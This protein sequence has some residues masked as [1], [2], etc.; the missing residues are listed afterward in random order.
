MS[1]IFISLITTG[2]AQ[3]NIE[4]FKPNGKPI[5]LIFPNFNTEFSDGETHPEFGLTRAYLGYEYNFS[6]QFYAKIVMDFGDP[7]AGSYQMVGFLKNAY[8]QYTN[9]KLTAYLGVISTTQFKVS[10]K[11]WGYRY[12]DKTFQDAYNFNS[13]ADLGFNIEY[14]FTDFL[15][16]D[17]SII[18][19]EGYKRLQSDDYLRPGFGITAKPIKNITTRIFADYM[20][21]E[22]KQQSLAL[23]LAYTG[24]KLTVGAEYNY[25]KNFA[26]KEG[27]DVY[28]PSFYASLRATDK[29][30]VFARYDHL[31]SKALPGKIDPW[32]LDDDGQLLMGGIELNIVKGIKISPNIRFWNPANRLSSSSIFAFLNLELRI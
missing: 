4:D 24:R 29:V 1:L 26:M 27:Q 18:N 16:A 22:I 20:G 23:F 17:F 25:Q 5:V 32:Q 13:S 3:E 31:K 21:D 15:S 12:I 9:N 7:K 30:N 8:I 2:F 10:E 14:E 19:G 28:G 6:K 11:I